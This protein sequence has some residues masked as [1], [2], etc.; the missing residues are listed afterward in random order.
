MEAAEGGVVSSPSGYL[1]S[2]NLRMQRM[3]IQIRKLEFANANLRVA[4]GSLR[5]KV[6]FYKKDF[7][8]IVGHCVDIVEAQDKFKE[9]VLERIRKKNRLNP[10]MK[11]D[12]WNNERAFW[13]KYAGV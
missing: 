12:C 6:K 5:K 13:D 4:N 11:C 2:D 10:V 1:A 8:K 7:L 9:R 3:E